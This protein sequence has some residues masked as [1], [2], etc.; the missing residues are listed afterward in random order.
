[1]S[2]LSINADVIKQI[3]LVYQALM[4][5]VM[6]LW[7]NEEQAKTSCDQLLKLFSKYI[8]IID[9]IMVICFFFL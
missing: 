1:M 7:S 4:M 3:L 2:N 8:R 6:N 5:Y 9:D